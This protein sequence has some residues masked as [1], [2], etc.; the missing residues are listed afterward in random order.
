MYFTGSEV[1]AA[2]FKRARKS[3]VSH[4]EMPSN[5][6]LAMQKKPLMNADGR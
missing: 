3:S 5:A 6:P 2:R 4:A 1:E